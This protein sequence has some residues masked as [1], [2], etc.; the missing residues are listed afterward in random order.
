MDRIGQALFR[1]IVITAVL[2][3]LAGM[4]ALG[5]RTIAHLEARI[6]PELAANAA[7]T[8]E[9]V[10]DRLEYA[11]SLGIPLE[12]LVGVEAYLA[13]ALESGPGV[14]RLT[15]R[16][17]EGLV[18]HS[19][20]SAGA[21]TSGASDALPEGG[22]A[23]LRLPIRAEGRIVAELEVTTDRH[24][25]ASRLREIAIDIAVLA[26]VS[27]LLA[28]E[29]L[30]LVMT[31]TLRG[32][33][34]QFGALV[35]RMAARDFRTETPASDMVV[36]AALALQGEVNA[37]AAALL[38]RLDA[39]R[40][41]ANEGGAARLAAV[42]EAARTAMARAGRFASEGSE[43]LRVSRL[44][45]VRGAALLFVLA[46]ELTRPFMPLFIQSVA[47]PLD[48]LPAAD[49]AFLVAIPISAFMA[50][51]ALTGPFASVFSDR[52]G[53]RRSFILGALI[54]TIA[55]AAT[56]FA[57][58]VAELAV[59]RALSGLGY[60]LT[61][62]AC[63]GQVID[64]TDATDRTVGMS[65]F[66][67]GIM[68]ADV[69]G[70]AIGGILANQIGYQ[71]TL[72]VAAGVAAFA[73]LVA[74]A[75]LDNAPFRGGGDAPTLGLRVFAACLSNG[76]LLGVLVFAA[77]PAKLVLSGFLFF[78]VP[79]LLIELGSTEAEIGRIAMVYGVAALLLMPALAG[80]CDRFRAHG[81]MVGAGALLTG[82]AL[83]PLGL[84]AEPILVAAAV[85]ALGVGQAMS[86][87][88]QTVL[89]TLVSAG[90]M[91][92]FGPGPVLGVFR[93]AERLGAVAGPL[94][95]AAT[96]QAHG[97]AEAA[98]VF[99]YVSI[100]T[101]TAFAALFLTVGTGAPETF[102]RDDRSG[103]DSQAP[104]ADARRPT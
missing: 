4:A 3:M 6:G 42:E 83:V 25:V 30:I 55:L 92:R 22:V 44:A 57:G 90:E 68:A 97:L 20:G 12:G 59:L 81:L 85:L 16:D 47:T 87:P 72:L 15:L 70:P 77:I 45:G 18:L 76:R 11:L 86:I 93:L 19:V 66:V 34:T 56:A 52:A 10:R 33:V 64:R 102:I 65:I 2:V 17:G 98:V 62:V 46:E 49:R 84:G 36:G 74:V 23:P 31:R 43:A 78:L 9:R 79:L 89:V 82:W 24:Y 71:A 35:A 53:R 99:G 7:V 100:A 80:F 14:A 48:A 58:S 29:V 21:E 61:F 51:V 41:R 101:G 50:G 38:L 28:V 39:L 67:G 104:A 5:L 96:A 37:R 103:A 91:E 60:A 88:A 40:A 54:S 63:Q 13:A 1:R 27:I 26:G 94:L 75:L 32:P 69:C 95:A 73:G 8:A